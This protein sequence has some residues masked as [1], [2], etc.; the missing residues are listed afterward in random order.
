MPHATRQDHAPLPDAFAVPHR[1]PPFAPSRFRS[2]RQANATGPDDLSELAEAIRA[3]LHHRPGL[4]HPTIPNGRTPPM[5]TLVTDLLIALA[6][7]HR[8]TLTI[9]ALR[10]GP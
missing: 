7:V 2:H 9:D 4:G 8:L 1:S 3:L 6:E 10:T 5:P